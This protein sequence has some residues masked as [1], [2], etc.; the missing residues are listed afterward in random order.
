MAPGLCMHT[1]TFLQHVGSAPS[2]DQVVLCKRTQQ[3]PGSKKT[4]I[5]D[6]NAVTEDA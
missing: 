1:H 3:G 2:A 6:V 4:E 5:S